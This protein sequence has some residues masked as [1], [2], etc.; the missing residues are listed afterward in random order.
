MDGQGTLFPAAG[1]GSS[2]GLRN[3]LVA[4]QPCHDAMA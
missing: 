4:R 1:S 3:F 2:G